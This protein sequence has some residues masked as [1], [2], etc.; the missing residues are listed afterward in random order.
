MKCNVDPSRLYALNA[1]PLNNEGVVLYWMS[2]DQRVD[3]N[4]ALLYAQELAQQQASTL[5]VVY[6]LAPRF[7]QATVRQYNFLLDGLVQVERQLKKLQIPFMLLL[8]DPAQEVIQLTQTM[9]VAA[10]VTEFDPLRI[11]QQWQRQVSKAVSCRVIEVDAHN[12]VPCRV[13]STKQEF[14]AY[15]LRP[16]LHKVFDEYLTPF[17]P[18]QPQPSS[19]Q[20]FKAVD[21][22]AVR[23]SLH[24]D[25]SVSIVDWCVPGEQ[26]ARTSLQQFI[27]QRLERYEVDRNNPTINAQ[28]NLSPYLHF[29]QLSAQR[30]ALD[31]QAS[32]VNPSTVSTFLEEL[33]IR[34][35]LS[36]N[37]CF[38]NSHY[39]AVDGFPAWAQKTLQE[40]SQDPRDYL[41]TQESFENGSTH[42]PL[43]NAAQRQMVLTGKMHGYMRMYWAKKILEWS[44]SPAQALSTAIYLN[45]KYQLD[46]R[47]PNGYAGIA[48]SIGGVHDRAWFDRPV[49]GKIRYMNYNGCKSKFDVD[50]YIQQCFDRA[51]S[52]T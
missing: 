2:R 9:K 15:T 31:V 27:E 10:I 23:Q 39:D 34:R 14:A 48:W 45:D 16:K 30:I 12:I 50:L 29:G 17:W 3:D 13:A 40:H 22:K 49:F 18:V 8:G 42:D 21:W 4:W 51:S 52:T 41:Y 32:G 7:L 26:A 33:I 5:V 11:K 43:W 1:K 38:Y 24:V 19:V 28:S 44:P 47:D 6:G 46:G 37:F 35:E 20:L 36:D 25:R